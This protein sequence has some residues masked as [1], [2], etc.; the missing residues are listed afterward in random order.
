M[1]GKQQT[2]FTEMFTLAINEELIVQLCLF[3]IE[4]NF[5]KNIANALAKVEDKVYKIIFMW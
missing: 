2:T 3:I 5:Y 1:E 4:Q